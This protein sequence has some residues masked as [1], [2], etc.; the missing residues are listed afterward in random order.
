[1][2]VV[3]A[4]VTHHRRRARHQP[5]HNRRPRADSDCGLGNRKCQ[6]SGPEVTSCP[7]IGPPD[8]KTELGPSIVI[9]SRVVRQTA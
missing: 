9:V 3:E 4:L 7:V 6:F 5:S 8:F 1:M 2:V